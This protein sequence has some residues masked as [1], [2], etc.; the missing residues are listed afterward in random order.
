MSIRMIAGLAHAPAI[1]HLISIFLV[2]KHACMHTSYIQTNIY[3]Y[4]YTYIYDQYACMSIKLIAGL[5]HAPEIMHLASIFLGI[6]KLTSV[7]GS[8]LHMF[9]IDV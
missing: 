6:Y 3:I 4:I 9:Y 7:S 2:Y 8:D 1:M 5:A